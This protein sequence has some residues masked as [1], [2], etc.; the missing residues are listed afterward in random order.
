MDGHLLQLSQE[1]IQLEALSLK[2]L[3]IKVFGVVQLNKEDLI[4]TIISQSS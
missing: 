3:D 4:M 2:I 1:L